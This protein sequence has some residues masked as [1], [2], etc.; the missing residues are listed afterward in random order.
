MKRAFLKV[1]AFLIF[2]LTIGC[3][4]PTK[5][6]SRIIKTRD[7]M[8][9]IGNDSIPTQLPIPGKAAQIIQ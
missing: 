2:L 5:R 8:K 9:E 4:S 6:N 3:L 1:Y 7:L